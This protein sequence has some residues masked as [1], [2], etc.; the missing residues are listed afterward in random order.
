[1][2]T[3]FSSR[4]TLLS[5]YH[6]FI[7]TFPPFSY[8][9]LMRN[10]GIFLFSLYAW[11]HHL[12]SY[13]WLTQSQGALQIIKFSLQRTKNDFLTI[14]IL[15]YKESSKKVSYQERVGSS[16]V[17]Y[18]GVSCSSQRSTLGF[19]YV[20]ESNN[21]DNKYLYVLSVYRIYF[22]TKAYL[23][24]SAHFI[25]LK[26]SLFLFKEIL[27]FHIFTYNASHYSITCSFD[28]TNIQHIREFLCF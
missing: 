1:M 28:E 4:E 14:W 7:S 5:I 12:S 27:V 6:H 10:W 11:K 2:H 15:F 9:L 25:L 17:F 13:P 3:F 24:L 23:H 8:W 19:L 18:K 16:W 22:F 21:N 26:F 20:H